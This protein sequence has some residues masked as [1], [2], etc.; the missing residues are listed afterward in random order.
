MPLS[1]L[2]LVKATDVVPYPSDPEYA[3]VRDF[4]YDF[5]SHNGV[6]IGRLTAPV[7]K[8]LI[9]DYAESFVVTPT[10]IQLH[11]DHCN[12]L[13]ARNKLIARIA[14][15]WRAA[16]AFRVLEGWR[17]ELYTVFNPSH[18]PY[19]LIER[20]ASMLFGVITYGVHIIGYV[21]ADADGCGSPLRVWVPR[22]SA[23]KATFP[24]MLDN[25]V[26][27]GL[28]YPYGL[29]ETCVKECY[30]E[31]GLSEDYVLKHLTSAGVITY[32][33]QHDYDKDDASST[34]LYQPEVEYIYD[35][36]MDPEIVPQP[37]DGEV[38]EF[39]LMT[40]EETKTELANGT[41][42]PNTALVQIDFFIRHGLITP[43]DEPDFLEIQARTHRK[44]EYPVR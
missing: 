11:P 14:A 5:I 29:L 27:G 44:M 35:L 19:L 43:E 23:T 2:D 40:V 4:S 26:A 24:G 20:A 6:K 31:A 7:Y 18:V 12:T 30:E 36:R 38:A 21:P 42:K 39:N 28:G 22:R 32:A 8:A 1:F 17:D 13:E 37:V 25:T 15:D 3:L 16:R 10:A 41:F 34:G 33:Y 9:A